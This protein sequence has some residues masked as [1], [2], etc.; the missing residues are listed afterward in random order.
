MRVNSLPRHAPLRRKSG[1]PRRLTCLESL[2]TRVLLS[3]FGPGNMN[4]P[5]TVAGPSAEG[6]IQFD[7][8]NNITG[9]TLTDSAGNITTP[10][11]NYAINL[12]GTL[13]MNLSA[14]ATTGAMN[15]T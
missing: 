13:T 8:A 6:S 7:S 15:S 5:W 10:A 3:A 11:G 12:D 9:G 2:E 1:T 4:G 14:V